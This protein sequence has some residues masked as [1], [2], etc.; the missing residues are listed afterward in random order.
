M[1]V[2]SMAEIAQPCE[3][4]DEVSIGAGDARRFGRRWRVADG[5]HARARLFI[6]HGTHEHGGRYQALADGLSDVDAHIASFDSRGHGESV[7][8]RGD[9]DGL[10]Q[11]SDDLMVQLRHAVEVVQPKRVIVSATPWGARC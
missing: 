5:T 4:P 8:K 7:G 3:A 11:L 6:F 10:A 9:A 1:H 2:H